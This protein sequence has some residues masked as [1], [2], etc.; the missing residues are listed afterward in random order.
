MG[1]IEIHAHRGARDI[2]PENTMSAFLQ[3][4]DAGV[5]AL[6]MDVVVSKDQCLVV[7]HDPWM[8]PDICRGPQ[9]VV[10]AADYRSRYRL[11]SMSY[12][13]IS[14]FDCGYPSADFPDQI[15]V[16]SV[17]PLLGDVVP[18]VENH[19]RCRQR[20]CLV[21]YNIELKSWPEYDG[22]YHPPPD[23]YA[24]LVAGFYRECGVN[25]RVRVQSFDHRLLQ[26]VHRLVPELATGLLVDQGQQVMNSLD[27]L[28]YLPDFVN[29]RENLV[30][31]RL[32]SDIHRRGPG[33][34]PWTVNTPGRMLELLSL[35]VDGL[36]TDYPRKAMNLLAEWEK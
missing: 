30:T 12:D 21:L 25:D 15:Y 36:I 2:R 20:S 18:E 29:P 4:V 11:Y 13:D 1:K 23:E 7:S 3:A 24:R 14:R 9:G 27:R 34:I 35:G 6:E 32:V 33:I 17:K 19:C 5:T 22:L 16:K 28:G 31:R 8:R 26:A 10:L